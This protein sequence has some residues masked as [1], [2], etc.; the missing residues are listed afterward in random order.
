M[1]ILKK[2]KLVCG[3]GI[4][5]ADYEVQPLVDGKRVPCKFYLAWKSMLV[6][7]Y[8]PKYQASRPTYT[9]CSVTSHWHR[10]MAFREW[11]ICQDWQGKAL[12]KDILHPGN[13]VYGPDRC[14]FVAPELNSFA[15]DYES[16][17]G[18]WPVGASW[19]KDLGKFQAQCC[20][21]FTG[22]RE[23]I[24]FFICPDAAHE[25]WRRRKHEIALQLAAQ[26]T[27]PRLAKALSTRYL[28]EGD[29]N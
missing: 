8:D 24:G 5:D 17:R 15:K 20:N 18:E 4:N 22:K 27:D 23:S 16:S 3:V 14:V 25:A 26:Q 2:R 28:K 12:D 21:P 7:C 6:R 9:G 29:A 19:R 10:F 11:M 13:K 1:R